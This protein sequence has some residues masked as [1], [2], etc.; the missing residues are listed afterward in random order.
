MRHQLAADRRAAWHRRSIENKLRLVSR[1]LVKKAQKVGDFA[2]SRLNEADAD[3]R[4][5][6]ESCLE[7]GQHSFERLD[8]RAQSFD[9]NGGDCF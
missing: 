4:F 6:T 3:V 1:H 7:I 2:L 9:R 5:D 8:L